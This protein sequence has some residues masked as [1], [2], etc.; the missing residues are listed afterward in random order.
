MLPGDPGW[1]HRGPGRVFKLTNFFI[2]FPSCGKPGFPGAPRNPVAHFFFCVI[3]VVF[4]VAEE[5]LFVAAV[6]VVF[7]VDEEDLFVAAVAVVFV[8]DEE[9]FFVAA[10]V[11]VDGY[12][13]VVEVAVVNVGVLAEYEPFVVVGV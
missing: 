4:V 3:V 13:V 6:A 12:L 1:G 2:L 5:D 7:V 8:V 11:V 9:D 10:V